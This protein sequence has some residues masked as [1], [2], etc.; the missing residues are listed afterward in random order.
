V[1]GSAWPTGRGA[2][3]GDRRQAC[4]E[5]GHP[6]PRR[7]DRAR[8]QAPLAQGVTD[9]GQRDIRSGAAVVQL[10]VTDQQHVDASR[11]REHSGLADTVVPGDRAHPHV[12]GDNHSRESELPAQETGHGGPRERGGILGVEATVENVRGHDGVDRSLRQERAVRGQLDGRIGGDG[13]IDEAVVGVGRAR[14]VSGEVLERREDAGGAHAL[15]VHPGVRRHHERISGEAPVSPH[16]HRVGG[17]VA[18]VDDRGQVPVDAGAREHEPDAPGLETRERDVVAGAQVAV[19]QC[20]VPADSRRQAHDPA[21]LGVD[22][23]QQGAAGA[24]AGAALEV[25]REGGELIR[26]RDVRPLEEHDA[27]DP[28]PT[29]KPLDYGVV[30]HPR[31]REA[32]EQELAEFVP[33]QWIRHRDAPASGDHEDQDQ[34]AADVS[35]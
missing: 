35:E 29:E 19:G 20:R 16:D 4:L 9:G 18:D 17:V 33:E 31:A 14:A 23:D 32:D 8:R 27:A 34:D 28:R 1:S 22:G 24:L 11:Q 21:A 3:D 13:D 30:Q 5:L 2:L 10:I 15:Q 25:S 12:V 7:G 6:V 26:A